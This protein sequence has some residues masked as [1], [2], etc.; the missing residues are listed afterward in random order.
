MRLSRRFVSRRQTW[1]RRRRDASARSERAPHL[2]QL[3]V[4]RSGRDAT[5]EPSFDKQ[6]VREYLEGLVN[7]GKWDKTP[8]GPELPAEVIEGT[9]ARYREAIE[10]LAK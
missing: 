7:A 6:F 9:L 1:S 10:Q 8:P 5:A 3:T 2:C 4:C